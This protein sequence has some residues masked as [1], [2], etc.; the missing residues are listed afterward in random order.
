MTTATQAQGSMART[1][2][3]LLASAVEAAVAGAR[4]AGGGRSAVDAGGLRWSVRT[5]DPDASTV[6]GRPVVLLHGVTSWS[7]C[8]WRTGPGLAAAGHR[9]YAPDLPGH[10][11]TPPPPSSRDG[12]PFPFGF[13]DAAALVAT[14]LAALPFG[15]AA[16]A[17]VGH[18]WGALV[19]AHLVAAGARLDRLILLDPP[20]LDRDWARS[21]AAEVRSPAS[22]DEAIAYAR[23]SIPADA[24]DD[25]DEKAD[26]LMHLDAATARAVLL[27]GSWDG[28]LPALTAPDGPLAAGIPT[29]VICADP[30]AGGYVSDAAQAR[31]AALLGRERVQVVPGS[32]H[33]LERS[34]P[35]ETLARLLQ[36]LEA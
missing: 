27:G 11:D 23:L 36:A 34:H 7:E 24:P 29:W 1:H 13:A 14:L 16:P 17:V 5:W 33:S 28:G 30:A 6:L 21:R 31:F 15:D 12:E 18:S 3:E 9:V 25:L 35:R 20:V 4:P 8:W 19:A 32:A 2:P 26:G 10:G 22:R